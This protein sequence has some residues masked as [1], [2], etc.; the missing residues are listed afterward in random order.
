MCACFAVDQLL[1]KRPQSFLCESPN[2]QAGLPPFL[3]ADGYSCGRVPPAYPQNLPE[4]ALS[5]H[6]YPQVVQRIA[7][8]TV[9]HSLSTIAGQKGLEGNAISHS[10][11][12]M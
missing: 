6:I 2:L 9:R 11:C 3:Q 1:Y 4:R 12:C 8:S 5:S 10:T 7:G